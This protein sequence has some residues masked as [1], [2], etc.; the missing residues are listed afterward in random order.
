VAGWNDLCTDASG[1]VYAGALRFGVFDPGATPVPGELWRVTSDGSA[2]VVYGDVIHPNGVALSPDE[3]TIYHSDTRRKVIVVHD[4]AEDGTAGGRRQIDVS[5]YG[6]PDG[7]AVDE[8]GAVWVA[9][10]GGF[11]LARFTPTGALDRRLEVPSQLVTSLCFGGGDGRS[12]YV[13]TGHHEDPA[14]R[15]CVLRTR[16]DVRGAR[17]HPARV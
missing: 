13:T 8:H 14:L 12:L 4:L 2:S 11:G 3:R 16:V 6:E 17:I 1:R 15:G 10:L 7:L 9:I 5:A